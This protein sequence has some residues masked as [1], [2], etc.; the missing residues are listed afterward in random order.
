MNNYQQKNIY[1]EQA[2]NAEASLKSLCTVWN[3][4]GNQVDRQENSTNQ[5]TAETFVMKTFHTPF[6]LGVRFFIEGQQYSG[7]VA[8]FFSLEEMQKNYPELFE[9]EGSL[10]AII[11]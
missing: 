10:H 8:Q 3:T 1:L 4:P 2:M 9:L 5:I 6:I 11:A 7:T